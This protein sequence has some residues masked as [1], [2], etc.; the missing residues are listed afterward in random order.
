MPPRKK[1]NGSPY[2]WFFIVVISLSVVFMV[3]KHHDLRAFT[4]YSSNRLLQAKESTLISHPIVD[5]PVASDTLGVR[6]SALDH[7]MSRET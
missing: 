6:R 1:Y 2:L 3:G 7:F 5:A 4:Q